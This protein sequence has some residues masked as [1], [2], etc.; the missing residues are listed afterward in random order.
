NPT[1]AYTNLGF[2]VA[3]NPQ[4][5]QLPTT[6]TPGSIITSILNPPVGSAASHF[7]GSSLSLQALNLID[8]ST[9]GITKEALVANDRVFAL[10]NAEDFSF[11]GQATTN[12]S[13]ALA[14]ATSSLTTL[15]IGD[16]LQALAHLTNDG[17]IR[18]SLA[19]SQ[20]AQLGNLVTA[21]LGNGAT[22]T[23]P[24][25]S[26]NATAP[27]EFTMRDGQTIILTDVASRTSDH[28]V[29]GSCGVYC[30]LLGGS[31]QASNSKTRTLLVITAEEIHTG[32]ADA[33]GL[34]RRAE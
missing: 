5:S 23:F 24:Q 33:S 34:G 4:G 18:I 6:A 11:V 3:L 26:D 20:T 32:D 16:Q 29:S 31:D 27:V 13:S 22:T 2:S 21:D 19:L 14:T 8:K 1:L 17:H 28:A 9:T 7:S 25:L 10:R 15:T 30:W 12:T